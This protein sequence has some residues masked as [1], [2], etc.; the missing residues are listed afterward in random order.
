MKRILLFIGIATLIGMSDCSTKR[1]AVG[2]ETD[3]MVVADSTIFAGLQAELAAAIEQTRLTPQPEKQFTIKYLDPLD[4]SRATVRHYIIM[5]G[6]LNSSDKTSKQVYSMLSEPLLQ[7]VRTGES[8][9]FQKQSPWAEEQLLLVLVG[10]DLETLRQKI[11]ENRKYLFDI[12]QRDLF[13]R[14]EKQVYSHY[15]QTDMERKL[16][17]DFG[18]TLRVQHD[19]HLYGR[20]KEGKFVC[21]R[22]T[23][24]ERWL[25]VHWVDTPDEQIIT[26]EWV[27]SRRKAI[28]S[29]YYEGDTIVDS[30][31]I[32][33]ETE[34]AGR[35]ALQLEG[36]WENDEKVA[37]GPF[38]TYAFYDANA[39]RAYLVDYAVFAPGQR[40][41]P[42]LRQLEVM[43]R[44]F[45]TAP[46]L[47][48]EA[49]KTVQVQR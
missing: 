31:L 34:F 22:R 30:L 19:Y 41:E 15:E 7:Q 2:E 43:A 24:P 21:L 47:Q 45:R 25:F 48:A 10:Q 8:F 20:D 27:V 12:L 40:K 6:L 39:R 28:G 3:V 44:T 29:R 38:T 46:D 17:Q 23:S 32:T 36:L 5:I 9:V 35:W 42:F 49:P 18:W 14:T 37:G 16:L 1:G 11:A 26:K 4:L 13:A 33:R